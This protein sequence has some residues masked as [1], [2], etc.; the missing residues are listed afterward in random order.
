MLFPRSLK[1]PI[2]V[3]LLLGAASA[4]L[5]GE[6]D[7]ER[8]PVEQLEIDFARNFVVDQK[9][10]WT[11]PFRLE[12]KDLLWLVPAAAITAETI[13][14]DPYLYQHIKF[15]TDGK[16]SKRFSEAGFLA[17]GS[18]VAGS[19]LIGRWKGNDH[20]RETGV[21]GTQAFLNA[22]AVDTALR[23]SLR[24]ERP[25]SR[26]GNG[27]FFHKGGDS[28]P[29]THAIGTWAMA[30]VIAH[31]YPGWL[32]KIGAYGLATGV[33]LTRVTGRQHFASD[34]LIG[35]ALGYGIGKMVYERHHDTE[36]GGARIG[37]FV[38]DESE[39]APFSGSSPY[40]PLDHWS[41]PAFDRLAA[42]GFAPSA[43]IS[44][45]PWTRNECRRLLQEIETEIQ[46]RGD[47]STKEAEDL[48]EALHLQFADDREPALQLDSIYARSLT[49]TGTP[50]T[51]GYHVGQTIV[52]D[53]GRHDREGFNGIGGISIRGQK[54]AF[55]YYARGE[56][57]S[58]PSE[59]PLRLAARDWFSQVDITPIA[60][61]VRTKAINR[62]KLLEGYVGITHRG[63]Q[64]SFGKQAADWGPAEAGAL[65]I[66]SNAEPI[67]MARLNRTSPLVLPSLLQYLGPVRFDAFFGQLS[68]HDFVHLD[69][70]DFGPGI[71]RQPL[72]HGAKFA[73]KP[74]RDFQFGVSVTTIF[75][76]P[77]TPFNT[78]TFLRSLGLSNTQPGQANDPGDRRSGVDILWRPP[79]LKRWASFYLDAMT[80]DEISPLA[81]PRRSAMAPGIYFHSVPGIP[82]LD[83]RAEGFYTDL[84]GLQNVGFYYYNFRYRSGY[85]NADSLI[86]HWVGRHG[87][88]FQL[89]SRYWINGRTNVQVVARNSTVAP[90][91]IPGGSYAES[92]GANLSW[93]SQHGLEAKALVQFEQWRTPLVSPDR[94]RNVAAGLQLTY[95]VH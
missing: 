66:S 51:D 31:E 63:W 7:R 86:G 45:R 35:S 87:S 15:S 12:R 76:G 11:S 26:V 19:Y 69:I 16:T 25:F 91:F 82:K 32:T 17:M 44:M 71:G 57:Q 95:R 85:T 41:Y 64:L 93:A 55:S 58:S 56:Y 42:M 27:D 74:T 83:F 5:G 60:P 18:A 40:V 38:P 67:L 30:T 8:T 47:D 53:Y 33:S 37:R 49:I 70:R 1:I 22:F 92:Y 23:Y 68:G 89:A 48:H 81:F 4:Q 14:H 29:S 72:I 54:G 46:L 24:R 43:F 73:F 90:Q 84:P 78:R 36:L 10:I 9:R 50:R 6:P 61:D 21:L 13:N 79:K 75:A 65:M 80:E 62:V 3:L 52:N 20:L 77:G 28:F 59:P 88:G 34:V 39:Q 2:C 94:Q